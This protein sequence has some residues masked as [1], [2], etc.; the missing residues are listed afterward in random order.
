MTL[1]TAVATALRADGV[2]LRRLPVTDLG[3]LGFEVVDVAGAIRGG[4]G[5]G[6]LGLGCG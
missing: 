1:P 3:L 4:R 6:L 5:G 2:G